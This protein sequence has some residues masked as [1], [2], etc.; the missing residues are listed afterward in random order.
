MPLTLLRGSIS[1]QL[2]VTSQTFG[3]VVSAFAEEWKRFRDLFPV[4]YP[5]YPYARHVGISP[6]GDSS[7]NIRFPIF[8][9]AG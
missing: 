8:I 3:L 6:G 5:C 4:V 2:Q 7:K 1:D 9:P